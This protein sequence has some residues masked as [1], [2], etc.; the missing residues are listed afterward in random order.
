MHLS[1]HVLGPF[2]A[3]VDDE[4]I[5]ESR[6]KKIE[7]LLVYL[8]VEM[9]RAHRR[10]TLVGL[11]F[12]DVPDDQARTNLRQTLTRLRR[13][14]NDKK[15]TPP[16]LLLTRESAQFNPDG[17]FTLDAV[18]FER[19]LQGCDDHRPQRHGRCAAC[20]RQ[21]AAAVAL[22]RGPFLDGF[23]LEDS[24]AFDE[25]MLVHR[26]RLQLLALDALRELA[27]YHERRGE[28]AAAEAAVRQQLT[29][30]PWREVA[31]RQLMRL[32][33]YQGQRTVALQQ[34]EQL[35][36]LLND[37]LD[38]APM[39]ETAALRAE[40][41]VMSDERRHTLPRRD[42]SFVGRVQEIGHVNGRL[43]TPECRLLTLVGIGGSGKT[44]L[45]VEAGW[46]AAEERVG[47]F[48]HGAYFV[49][50]AAVTLAEDTPT[51][52]AL[53]L[54][55]TAVAT[56]L[57][58]AFAGSQP[59][60]EQLADYLC[61]K[62]LLL[63]LDNCEHLITHGRDFVR[64]LLQRTERLKILTTSRERLHLPEEWIVEVGGLSVT[65]QALEL[66]VQR[67]QR[68]TAD[69]TLEEN[70]FGCPPAAVTE[71]CTLVHGLPLGIELAASWVH[72][73]NCR[74]IVQEIRQNIDFLQ[75]N[76]HDAPARHQS[77]RAVF[78]Y[79]WNLLNSAE[80]RVLRQLAVFCGPFDRQAAA[81]IAGAS[82]PQLAALV[83]RSLL[84]R[85]TDDQ[86]K[87][88]Y[89][90]LEVLRQYT[91]EKLA[92]EDAAGATAVRDSHARYYLA[93][94]QAQGSE[95]RRAKQQ[96]ALEEIAAAMDNVRTAWYRAGAQA[97]AAALDAALEALGLFYYMRSWF[98]E[99]A[100]EFAQAADRLATLPGDEARHTWAK[101]L[102]QQ[103]WFTF[104]LGHQQEGRAL[105]AQS[106]AALRPFGDAAALAFALDFLAVVTYTLGDLAQA[107]ALA[108][109][110][111]ALSEAIG[112]RYR[113]AVS[114]N[115]LS[116]IA[117]RRDDYAAAQRYGAASLALE[118]ASGN[119]WSMGFSFTNLGRVAYATGDFAAA[120]SH[121]RQGLAIREAL[122]DKRGQALCLLY[123]GDTA[124]AQHNL[125]A[126]RAAYG[127]GRILFQEINNQEG[128]AAA[129][130]RLG[131]LALDGDRRAARQHF[132]AALQLASQAQA[133]P[134]LLDALIGLATVAAEEAPQRALAVARLVAYHPAATHESRAAADA[135]LGAEAAAVAT[136]AAVDA[137][138]AAVQAM[139]AVWLS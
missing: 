18:A 79:S 46:R 63:I 83:D 40:I 14:I 12:P 29:I 97:D 62:A 115:I 120:E 106:V 17:D 32:L 38:V 110:G 52:R 95:L 131:R 36:A 55:A 72:L 6:S 4:A 56:A 96:V 58:F 103:G 41:A 19:L 93:F 24:V 13:A 48:P 85:H 75:N 42:V 84:Q 1:I 92:E 21:A 22:Y 44:A 102:A 118:R 53:N 33:A 15:A 104:L 5:P 74:E 59:P 130:I 100:E 25:W 3:E 47:P 23:F 61:D 132:Q 20:M 81:A 39:P 64:W 127:N 28:Y 16:F 9:Q 139:A 117:Y 134:R 94:L 87:T 60:H 65:E 43:A 86:G 27:D 73:L 122:R 101:L 123:L 121:F 133:V 105:L 49:P 88:R 119:R 112:D 111:L 125:D 67:A 114:N 98:S 129:L 71:I 37:E 30:E 76:L 138:D 136:E 11:L 99:G 108:E 10:E 91:A 126:A 31:H 77:L 82:L 45:A 66:F 78:A 2:Q 124:V 34:Y 26:E 135:L 128:M 35:R 113:V 109:E 70:S 137:S 50:L 107:Q 7:A 51:E 68:A 57:D 89:E 80:R 54:L 8:A 69:F 90:L 116:Q